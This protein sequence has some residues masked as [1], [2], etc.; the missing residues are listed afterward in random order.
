[1]TSPVTKYNPSFG[2]MK[3]SNVHKDQITDKDDCL[4]IIET[5]NF[6]KISRI[7]YIPDR[8]KK[9][10]NNMYHIYI[11]YSELNEDNTVLQDYFSEKD[12]KNN[13]LA[14][15]INHDLEFKN[16]QKHK[17]W[18]AKFKNRKLCNIG[19]K[20]WESLLT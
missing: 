6:G 4:D 17:Y 16:E 13:K 14:I 8:S 9:D 11:S 10:V 7:E 20:I 2:I 15:S 1:M 3:V 5:M 12:K 18:I 19:S